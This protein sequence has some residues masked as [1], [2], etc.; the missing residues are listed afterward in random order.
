MYYLQLYCRVKPSQPLPPTQPSHADGGG[1]D[2]GDGGGGGGGGG[3]EG[4]LEGGVE[5]GG[6]VVT[7][8]G[9]TLTAPPVGPAV[10]AESQQHHLAQ[11][12]TEAQYHQH[13]QVELARSDL[14]SHQMFQD[15]LLQSRLYHGAAFNL[16]YQNPVF[17]LEQGEPGHHQQQPGKG[18]RWS[19]R[20]NNSGRF[21]SVRRV[22]PAP[23]PQR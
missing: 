22:C 6:S 5:G 9:E 20:R 12:E 11:T 7:S 13:Q 1:R 18:R 16:G 4:G 10:T 3:G 19:L 14:S 21:D 17:D 23:S 15:V 8:S 2:E